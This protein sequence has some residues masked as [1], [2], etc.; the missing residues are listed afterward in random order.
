MGLLIHRTNIL[1]DSPHISFG[2]WPLG[3]EQATL[4]W[5]SPRL[6]PASGTHL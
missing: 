2:L 4:L 6:V 5:L 1:G 3:W